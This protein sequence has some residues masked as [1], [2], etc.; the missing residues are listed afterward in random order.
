M[1]VLTGKSCSG[2]DTIGK[3]LEKLGI[4]KVITYTTRPPR[5]NEVDGVDYHFVS[6]D[7]FKNLVKQGF[8]A[9]WRDYETDKGIWLYGSAKKDYNI[10]ANKYIILNL[11]SVN[12]IGFRLWDVSERHI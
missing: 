10:A 1:I 7:N 3:E 11:K 12:P 9:E 4:H 2:K 5:D 6:T 8:F